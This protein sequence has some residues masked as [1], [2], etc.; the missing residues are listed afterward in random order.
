MVNCYNSGLVAPEAVDGIRTFARYN[1]GDGDSRF[2]NC[3]EVAGTQVQA[4]EFDDVAS[5]KL[6]YDLNQGAGATVFYQTIGTDEHPVLDNTHGIVILKDG[7]Y[8]NGEE[9]TIATVSV[10]KNCEGTYTLSGTRV[11]SAHRGLMIIR[12]NDGTVKKILK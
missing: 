7:Q 3:F 6:C 10:N 2:V 5:G 1:G 12:Q 9:S 11:S 8:V 4:A